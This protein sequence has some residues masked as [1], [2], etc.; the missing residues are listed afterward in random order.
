[1]VDAD[2]FWLLLIPSLGLP[3]VPLLL[4]LPDGKKSASKGLNYIVEFLS[5]GCLKARDVLGTKEIFVDSGKFE[6]D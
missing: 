1:M 6:L 4:K 3:D 2:V 5:I